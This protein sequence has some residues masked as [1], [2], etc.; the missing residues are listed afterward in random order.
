[1]GSSRTACSPRRGHDPVDRRAGLAEN[2][3]SAAAPASST[4]SRAPR[5]SSTWTKRDD[6]GDRAH[7]SCSPSSSTGGLVTNSAGDDDDA[8]QPEE[9]RP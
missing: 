2:S 9:A 1:L 6:L 3:S 5:D 7:L 8:E 4:L